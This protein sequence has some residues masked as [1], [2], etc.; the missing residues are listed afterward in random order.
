MGR[1]RLRGQERKELEGWQEESRDL[2]TRGYD[3]SQYLTELAISH[4]HI[5]YGS[6]ALNEP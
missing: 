2:G 6:N 4:T 5:T 1:D 3:K